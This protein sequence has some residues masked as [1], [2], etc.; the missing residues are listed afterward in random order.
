MRKNLMKKKLTK[1]EIQANENDQK[2]TEE[3]GYETKK[4][5]VAQQLSHCQNLLAVQISTFCENQENLMMIDPF[6]V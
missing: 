4:F 5:D 1:K 6:D 2:T 3:A